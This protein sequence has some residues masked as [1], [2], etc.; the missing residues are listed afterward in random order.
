MIRFKNKLEIRIPCTKLRL[1]STNR[2]L[3]VFRLGRY[4][5]FRQS[6]Q[7]PYIFNTPFLDR[8]N[9]SV[10][11]PSLAL[12]GRELKQIAYIYIIFGTYAFLSFLCKKLEIFLPKLT[13]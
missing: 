4:R 3:Y 8:E 7:K 13:V 1:V 5:E 12:S 2:L 6:C 11:I 10:S 9:S